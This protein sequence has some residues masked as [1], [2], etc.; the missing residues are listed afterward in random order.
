MLCSSTG[1]ISRASCV[2]FLGS[3]RCTV[4]Q[5]TGYQGFLISN[6]DLA[7]P[8]FLSAAKFSDMG[9]ESQEHNCG[10]TLVHLHVC[11]CAKPCPWAEVWSVC[12]SIWWV[13]DIRDS[14]RTDKY[15]SISVLADSLLCSACSGRVQDNRLR[16]GETRTDSAS[17]KAQ[18]QEIWWGNK[19]DRKSDVWRLQMLHK[20]RISHA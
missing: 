15:I 10:L 2:L 12:Q 14:M 13:A 11:V 1:L 19:T 20:N 4:T 6:S 8:D 9:F 17:R 16:P 7:G 5:I 18:F 3:L